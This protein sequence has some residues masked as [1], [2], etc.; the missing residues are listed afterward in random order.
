MNVLHICPYMHPSAGGP[1]VVV[2]RLAALAPNHGWRASVITTS[3]FCDDNG[4]ALETQLNHRINAS[5]LPC[6]RPRALGLASAAAAVIDRGVRESDFVHLHTLW[7]PLNTL[8]RRACARF[9]RRYVLMPHGMLDPYSLGVRAIRK[10][11][12]MK[13]R[14]TPNLLGA[15]RVIFTT[16]L[17]EQLA[18]STLPWLPGGEIV[19]LGADVPPRVSRDRLAAAFEARF[20]ESAGRRCM[21]FLGRIHPKKGLER[22]LTELPRI[23]EA[24]PDALLVVA[25][26][27]EPAY[28]QGLQRQVHRAGLSRHA[29]FTGLLLGDLKWGALAA[30]E[31]FL[32]PSQ[33]ENFAIAVAEAMQMAVP[34][35][36]SEKVNTWPFIKQA[37][38]GVVLDIARPCGE[39]GAII[40]TLLNDRDGLRAMGERGRNFARDNFTWASTASRTIALYERL[41]GIERTSN[42]ALAFGL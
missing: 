31:L 11:L 34:V 32:L 12:Y 33:Q 16:P 24:C 41:L 20:P 2:E 8:A 21:V 7:H 28:V 5:V 9:G 10:R 27:G 23:V 39:L 15:S 14:E 19:P 22:I 29:T 1:P 36:V 30:A 18:R 40:V 42:E 3:L 38:A 37:G 35:I 4:S 6:D 26:S 17:E 13:L 25:G